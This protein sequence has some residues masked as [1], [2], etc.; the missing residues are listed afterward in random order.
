LPIDESRKRR[1]T[2]QDPADENIPS[3]AL[4]SDNADDS[5]ATMASPRMG[6]E[7]FLSSPNPERKSDFLKPLPR[8]SNFHEKLTPL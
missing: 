7:V 4:P 2:Q 8:Y 5:T 3:H 1:Q 6:G